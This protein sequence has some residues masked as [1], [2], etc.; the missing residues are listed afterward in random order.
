MTTY[1]G[2]APAD[3]LDERG[4]AADRPVDPGRP[5]SRRS[6]PMVAGL[7]LGWLIYTKLTTD[8]GLVV[9]VVVELCVRD[10]WCTRR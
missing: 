8:D 5:R 4:P 3:G 10:G 9:F 7:M 2:G 6:G 1:V